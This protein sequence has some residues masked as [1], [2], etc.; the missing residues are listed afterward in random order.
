MLE[1]HRLFLLILIWMLFCD[2][3]WGKY[4]F[5]TC[6]QWYGLDTVNG[7]NLGLQ[8]PH[9]ICNVLHW[10][11]TSECGRE[12]YYC[13]RRP[14]C[15]KGNKHVQCWCL[16]S[17]KRYDTHDSSGP[18]HVRDTTAFIHFIMQGNILTQ[19]GKGKR[20]K[21]I[22]RRQWNGETWVIYNRFV[23]AVAM[24]A[25]TNIKRKDTFISKFHVSWQFYLCTLH[26]AV[27]TVSKI[28]SHSIKTWSV[29]AQNR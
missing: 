27:H 19:V 1:N 12:H 9:I 28:I 21:G 25:L 2:K 29:M 23:C 18:Y 3:V 11:L 16:L 22:S 6:L 24:Q 14:L 26:K 4:S 10:E 15:G 5:Q 20:R 13:I 8:S 7:V 17:S